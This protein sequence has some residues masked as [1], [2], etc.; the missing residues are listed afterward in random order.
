MYFPI[1]GNLAL[2]NMV[3]LKFGNV[4]NTYKGLS[5]RDMYQCLEGLHS[6]KIIKACTFPSK[7]IDA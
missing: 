1:K 4:L 5:G 3:S 2:A 7:A 6:H